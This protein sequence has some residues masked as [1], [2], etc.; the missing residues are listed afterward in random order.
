MTSLEFDTNRPPQGLFGDWDERFY[1]WLPADVPYQDRYRRGRAA[2]HA[3]APPE[4]L[5]P[6]LAEP[7]PAPPCSGPCCIPHPESGLL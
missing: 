3:G 2:L 6:I 4:Q 5:Q 1:P 7:P